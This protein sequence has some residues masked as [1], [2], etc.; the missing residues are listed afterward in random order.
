[1]KAL[2]EI[3]DRDGRVGRVVDL[4]QWP[5]TLGR[6]LGNDVVLDDAFVAPVHAHL[7]LGEDDQVSLR[8]GDSRNGVLVGTVHHGAGQQ[9]LLPSA[10]TALQIGG[11][12]LRLRLPGEVLAPEQALP[13]VAVTPWAVPAGA[14]L[15]VMLLALVNHWVSL[16]P[17]ADTQ[18]W[19][20]VLI[21]LPLAVAG[22]CGA[23]AL[24]SKIF[25]HRFDF[26]GHLRI[27]LPWL[28]AIELVDA[29]LQPLAASLA[30]PWLW[31]LTGPL[32]VLMGLLLLRAHLAHVLPTA[33]RTVTAVVATAAVV[34]AAISLT[35]TQRATDRWS[36]PAYMSLLP[37]PMLNLAG[38]TTTEAL[39]QD[40]T[41]V[42]AQLAQRVQ[43]ARTEEDK[44]GEAATE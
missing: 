6:A 32:Q 34:G 26:L 17:G 39:V 4:H 27:V 25:Q 22:W 19:L 8:V 1:M 24:A 43:K 14:G 29:L 42:A 20:P 40:L 33:Q 44:D 30:W 36:R 12:K 5:V 41:P 16:D 21:G 35:I 2:L 7:H 13:A 37:I 10:G 18:A 38:A 23:W 15:L 28:L 3:I 11:L 9:V 31:R